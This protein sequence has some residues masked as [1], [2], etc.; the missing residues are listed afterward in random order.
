MYIFVTCVPPTRRRYAQWLGDEAC[1]KWR[2][3]GKSLASWSSASSDYITTGTWQARKG[4]CQGLPGVACVCS[5]LCGMDHWLLTSY[6]DAGIKTLGWSMNKTEGRSRLEKAAIESELSQ[7]KSGKLQVV[8]KLTHGS[9]SKLL[10]SLL[11]WLD[12]STKQY[13]LC[14][15][16]M[17]AFPPYNIQML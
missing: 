6:G 11:C 7:D 2:N 12:S 16:F 15:I 13:F 1:T 9:E 5:W 10:A 14:V 4:G 8:S 17:T 3:Q